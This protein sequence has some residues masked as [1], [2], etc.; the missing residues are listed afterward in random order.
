MTS[1]TA[2][3][4]RAGLTT[5]VVLV[6]AVVLGRPAGL[7][8]TAVSPMAV[9]IVGTMVAVFG[10]AGAA[11]RSRWGV[12]LLVIGAALLL[13]SAAYFALGLIQP[14]GPASGTGGGVAP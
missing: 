8:A 6:M 5:A 2:S 3:R 1:A 11:R 9:W 13:G 7:F 4:R 10:L 12:V 14:D